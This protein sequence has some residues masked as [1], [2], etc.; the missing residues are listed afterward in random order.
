MA[1]PSGSEERLIEPSKHR[2]REKTKNETTA[3]QMESPPKEKSCT[4]PTTKTKNLTV[5]MPNDKQ[6]GAKSDH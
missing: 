6:W 3:L 2:R 5:K 1:R 4:L